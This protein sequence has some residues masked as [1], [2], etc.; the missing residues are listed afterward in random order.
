[1]VSAWVRSSARVDLIRVVGS[2]ENLGDVGALNSEE[3]LPVEAPPELTGGGDEL[4]LARCR[5]GASG[6]VHT[7]PLRT[8]LR[9][10]SVQ[11]VGRRSSTCGRSSDGRSPRCRLHEVRE[12]GLVNRGQR[13]VNRERSGGESEHNP[14]THHNPPTWDYAHTAN[15]IMLRSMVR[16]HLAHVDRDLITRR[17][18]PVLTSAIGQEFCIVMT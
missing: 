13:E 14:H 9:G 16:F 12:S 7:G 8:T 10:P 5:S 1:M 6:P 2:L 4:A 15:L 11:E 17:V 3:C 18:E